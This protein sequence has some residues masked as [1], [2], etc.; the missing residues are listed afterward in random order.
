MD[1]KHLH[2]LFIFQPTVMKISRSVQ[3]LAGVLAS[4]L[5]T[6]AVP[7]PTEGDVSRRQHSYI[8]IVETAIAPGK[9]YVYE[10]LRHG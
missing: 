1:A 3:L 6:N 8:D 5:A 7:S 9:N 10:D 2:L 4:I